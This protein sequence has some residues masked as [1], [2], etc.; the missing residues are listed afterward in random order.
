MQLLVVELVLRSVH[1]DHSLRSLH[2]SPVGGVYGGGFLLLSGEGEGES[3]NCYIGIGRW[4]RW[5]G[6]ARDLLCGAAK[7]HVLILLSVWLLFT[8]PVDPVLRNTANN[9]TMGALPVVIVA[10]GLFILY[11]SLVPSHSISSSTL[12]SMN[13]ASPLN[14][15]HLAYPVGTISPAA[16][17]PPRNVSQVLPKPALS[18]PTGE[19]TLVTAFYKIPNKHYMTKFMSWICNFYLVENPLV[20]FTN[21]ESYP[22]VKDLRP[23]SLTNLTQWVY[24][25]IG[26]FTAARFKPVFTEQNAR[27]PEISVGHSPQLYMVWAEKVSFMQRV[28]ETNPFRSSCFYWIDSGTF[29][30]SNGGNAQ[31]FQDSMSDVYRYSWPSTRVCNAD[32]GHVLFFYLNPGCMTEPCFVQDA[33]LP[34][35]PDCFRRTSVVGGFFGGRPEP[36]LRFLELYLEKMQLWSSQGV[37][38][39]KD[40]NLFFSVARKNPNVVKLVYANSEWFFFHRFMLNDSRDAASVYGW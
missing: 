30:G 14:S 32:P 31:R 5:R 18:R 26:N 25:E 27:D 23:P 2:A 40:Q 24:L 1:R 10:Y 17:P 12:S 38:I 37:F 16:K 21:R 22:L 29:R 34:F 13:N 35:Y 7:I 11:F 39:D 9:C 19:V 15:M 33:V 8:T 4:W 28:I 20:I 36:I 3:L 6:R